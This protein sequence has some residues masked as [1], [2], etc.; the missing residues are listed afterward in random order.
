[1]VSNNNNTE[2]FEVK[3]GEELKGIPGIDRKPRNNIPVDSSVDNM[4]FPLER[5]PNAFSRNPFNFVPDYFG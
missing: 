3:R 2:I 1:M 5:Q 4:M